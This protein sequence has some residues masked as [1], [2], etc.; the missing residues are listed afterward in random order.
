MTDLTEMSYKQR[1]KNLESLMYT[2]T[3][4]LTRENVEL[5]DLLE[6]KQREIM[7]L[8]RRIHELEYCLKMRWLYE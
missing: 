3:H 1:I 6:K 2:E 5:M 4:K 7:H 8:K